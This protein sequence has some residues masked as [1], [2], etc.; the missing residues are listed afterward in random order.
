MFHNKNKIDVD[1]DVVDHEILVRVCYDKDE[2]QNS[3]THTK[4]SAPTK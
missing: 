2:E 3:S 4:L 1:V